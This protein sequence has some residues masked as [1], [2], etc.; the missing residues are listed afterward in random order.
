M[1]FFDIITL[2][3]IGWMIFR[4]S[5]DGFVSQLLSLVGI[6]VGVVLA[7]T[8]GGAV[9]NLLKID[10]QYAEIS[11]FIIIFIVAVIIALI[12]SKL[13]S[14]IISVIKLNWLNTL[15]GILF[16]IVKGLVVLSFIYAAIFALNERIKLID[17]KEFDKSISFNVVR[18]VANPLIKYWEQSKPEAK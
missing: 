3:V 10:P 2:V 4:G 17:E 7:I 8:Y 1:F 13:L 14:K 9:G 6:I 12:L 11:G 5:K 16:S 15:L 18:S